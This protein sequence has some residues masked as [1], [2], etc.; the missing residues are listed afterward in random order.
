MK[1]PP[2]RIKFNKEEGVKKFDT[3]NINSSGPNEAKVQ[4]TYWI[5]I[6]NKIWVKE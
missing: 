3:N 1:K 6:K 2:Q 5:K 4:I